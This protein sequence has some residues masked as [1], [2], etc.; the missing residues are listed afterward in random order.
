MSATPS[1]PPWADEPAEP[2]A[3]FDTGAADHAG[4]EAGPRFVAAIV[5]D[6]STVTLRGDID[7]RGRVFAQVAGELRPLV[8]QVAEM[9]EHEPHQLLA[10]AEYL[11]GLLDREPLRSGPTWEAQ[12]VVLGL[13]LIGLT[14]ALS[15]IERISAEEREALRPAYLRD[16]I[17]AVTG[18]FDS[19]YIPDPGDTPEEAVTNH[20]TAPE[21]SDAPRELL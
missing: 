6:R 12:R 14:N 15:T 4:R 11:H 1:R 3:Y 20:P 13:F 19:T 17:A 2:V 5:E 7:E 21:T 16:A 8:F 9:A 10:A 18:A